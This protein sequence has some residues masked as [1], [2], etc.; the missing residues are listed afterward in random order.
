LTVHASRTIAVDVGRP[1]ADVYSYAV[2]VANLPKWAAGLGSSGHRDGDAWVS[3]TDQ[4]VIRIEFVPRNEL[5]VLDH[6]VTL[7]DGSVLYSPMRV[8]ANGMGSHVSFTLFHLPDV[9]EDA[10][11]ADAAMIQKDLRTLKSLLEK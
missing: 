4:G 11:A 10:F 2:D 5:G 1:P 3:Q 7:P 6:H 8:I 9:A